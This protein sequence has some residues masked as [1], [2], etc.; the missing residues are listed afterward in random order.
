MGRGSSS[1]TQARFTWVQA[2]RSGMRN[3]GEKPWA[4]SR[5]SASI[6]RSRGHDVLNLSRLL[7]RLK[8]SR[9]HAG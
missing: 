1:R 6:I 9:I 5:S 8:G 2:L 3:W 7:D 4:F